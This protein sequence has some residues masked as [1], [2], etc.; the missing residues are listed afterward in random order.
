MLARQVDHRLLERDFQG[1]RHL[2]EEV[3]EDAREG[4]GSPQ[5]EDRAG[6]PAVGEVDPRHRVPRQMPRVRRPERGRRTTEVVED[7]HWLVPG[8]LR[9]EQPERQVDRR[10]R[11]ADDQEG[12]THR[13]KAPAPAAGSPVQPSLQKAALATRGSGLPGTRAPRSR[14]TTRRARGQIRSP[15]PPRPCRGR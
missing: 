12:S 10:M 13:L 9:E 6:P 7:H 15:L 8:L 4:P 1:R 5:A 2:P 11:W 3:P 14:R